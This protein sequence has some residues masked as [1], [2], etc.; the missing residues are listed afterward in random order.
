MPE[1]CGEVT[2]EIQR[3]SWL[4]YLIFFFF[5]FTIC[6]NITAQTVRESK[7]DIILPP[8]EE[9]FEKAGDLIVPWSETGCHEVDI[10]AKQPCHIVTVDE[11]R[12]R[13]I[14]T[15]YDAD[16]SIWLR[17]SLHA[18]K[19]DSI[20]EQP[21][22]FVPFLIEGTIVILRMVGES[23]HWYEVEINEN[24][25]A[26]KFILKSDPVWAKTTWDYWLRVSMSL[27]VDGSRS[28][29]LDKP[30]GKV[31][32]E[33]ATIPFTRVGFIKAEEDWAYVSIYA[34]QKNYYGWIRWRKGRDVLVGWLYTRRKV[35]EINKEIKEQ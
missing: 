35:P 14:A 1:H 29:L 7:K 27:E 26:T 25:R 10:V 28:P 33:T 21:N 23:E 11:R 30:N 34:N 17:F 12:A 24:T 9:H 18:F 22:D 3:R 13:E 31:I 6:Q 16:G 4:I 8:A 5:I 32:E 20:R 15:I 2:N 19:I